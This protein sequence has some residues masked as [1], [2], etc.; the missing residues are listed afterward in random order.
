M[1]YLV[2]YFKPYIFLLIILILFV[3]GQAFV[4]LALPD[5]MSKIITNGIVQ[6]DLSAVWSNGVAMLLL[7]LLGG[8]FTIIVGFL[9]ARISAGYTHRLRG[10]V[11][12]KVESFS[13]NEFNSFSSSSLITRSTNDMQQIQNVMAMV[14]RMALL[15][16]FMGIGAIIKAYQLAPSMTWIMAAAIGVMVALI[17]ML[18]IVVIPKFTTIQKLVDKLSL[19]TREM[20]TGVR[21]IR[22]YNNDEVQQEKF[23]KTNLE[24]VK[25]NIFVNRV[26]S[27]M[28]P[29]MTLV[30]GLASLAVVWVGAY[31]IND[32]SL[33]VGSLFALMQYV[34][35]TIFAFLMISMMFIMVPRAAVSGRRINEVLATEPTIVEPLS[36]ASLPERINGEVEFDKVEF[37]YVGSEQPVLSGISFTA[38]PGQTTAIIGGTGSGKSTILNLIPR[39][40]DV[41]KGSIAID[42]IDIREL[43]QAELH[44]HVGYIPQKASLFS[45]TV[46]SN[47]AYGRPGAD[48]KEI[49]KAAETA[50]AMEFINN[51]A[52]G[53]DNPISQAGSNI[54][55]GQKQRLSIA[56]ALAKKPEIYLFD[57]SFSALDFKTDS[58]LR[59]A[60]KNEI[61]K[62]TLII[63]AQR[64]STIMHA[65]KIVVLDE[66]KIVGVGTHHELLKKSSV[67]REI[68][69]SQLSDR[70]LQGVN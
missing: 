5:Y 65:D 41:S 55:G 64:I 59:S 33:Q 13:L 70:E 52:D 57:D 40:Y 14:L 30:M 21:V 36:P 6:K 45:G 12:K 68:A 51:L 11:F 7:T 22:A 10:A 18:F 24:S 15:G 67:Y 32:G 58:R 23:N 60:L 26:M 29:V 61:S 49:E 37:G 63:V 31:L 62:A 2:K 66:G 43:A 53:M 35:Q 56:R 54:S 19:Q 16:P 34:M 38:M 25:L 44:S 46:G 48:D 17:F 69:Q 42:G 8:I 20:L 1:R 27:L 47:I 28:M 50:Q 4:N 9:A 3:W 39:L